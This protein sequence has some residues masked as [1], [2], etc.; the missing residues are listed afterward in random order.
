M[1]KEAEHKEFLSLNE[2]AEYLGVDYKTVYRYIKD[3]KNP[4][5]AIQILG[6]TLRVNKI[7]LDDWLKEYQN[8]NK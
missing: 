5:P 2:V 6:R 7:K 1:I 8:E 4:L 3:K